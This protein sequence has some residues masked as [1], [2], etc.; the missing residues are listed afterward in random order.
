MNRHTATL[1]ALALGLPLLLAG[2]A[3]TDTT[4]SASPSPSA[5]APTGAAA[6]SYSGATDPGHW[7]DVSATCATGTAQSPININTADLNREPAQAP[8]IHYQASIFEVEN[9]GHTIEA[10]P[11]N[12][13]DNYVVINGTQYFLQQFHLH[14]TSEHTIDGKHADLEL[15]LVNKSAD[16]AVAVLGVL[17]NAGEANQALAGLFDSMP[18]Y[19]S[20][21]D[22][23]E[24]I[25][26]TLNPADLFPAGSEVLEYE[27]SLTTPPCTEGVH[28]N[29]YQTPGAISAEQLSA[30]QALYPKNARP[31]QDLDGRSVNEVPAS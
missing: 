22:H 13:T 31:V 14:T 12:H 19:V 10:A 29:V 23:P 9:N 3:T 21:D 1:S 20:A 8:E 17:F 4:P 18:K 27:G 5:S 7:G 16:G 26:G 24:P 15:H 25:P 6:W 30:F 28:W 11:A 2:C